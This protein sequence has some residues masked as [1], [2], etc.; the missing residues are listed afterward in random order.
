MS[1]FF[2]FILFAWLSV[3]VSYGQNYKKALKNRDVEQV[4]TMFKGSKDINYLTC[5]N[6]SPLLTACR[7]PYLPIIKVLVEELG[8]DV[9]FCDR[10]G[11]S[12]LFIVCLTKNDSVIRYLEEKGAKHNLCSATAKGDTALVDAFLRKGADANSPCN[13]MGYTP[14]ILACFKG[15]LNIVRILDRQNIKPGVKCRAMLSSCYYGKLEVVKYLRAQGV[16]HSCRGRDS[17]TCLM[18]AVSGGHYDI[19]EYLLDCGANPNDTDS[20]G[21]TVLMNIKG[22]CRLDLYRLL[23]ERGASV[24][25]SDNILSESSR[26]CYDIVQYLTEKGADLEAYKYES[27]Y[28][29]LMVAIDGGYMDIARYLKS[30]GAKIHLYPVNNF[31]TKQI[32][33]GNLAGLRFCIENGIAVD[34][35]DAHGFTPLLLASHYGQLEIVKYLVEKGANINLKTPN[36]YSAL[37][38]ARFREFPEIA[39]Y[40]RSVGAKE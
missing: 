14:Y 17:S 12:P 24:N 16:D 6:T 18:N 4:R 22:G 31:L 28:T 32:E 20:N 19:A 35:V 29:A 2:V 27:G 9:N 7:S 21:K 34:T 37:W 30:K 5:F 23:I 25:K 26:G 13:Y 3:G 1:R 8:A 38:W 11:L 39:T 36:G 33:K 40:L 10:H 15:N